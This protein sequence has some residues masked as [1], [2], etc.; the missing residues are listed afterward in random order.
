MLLGTRT[1]RGA[2]MVAF[3]SFFSTGIDPDALASMANNY[4]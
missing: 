2:V 1:G 4:P 3:A